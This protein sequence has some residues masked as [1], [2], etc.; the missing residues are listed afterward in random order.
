MTGLNT[1]NKD[2]SLARATKTLML[3][4]PF[5]GLLLLSLIKLWTKKINTAAVGVKG[6]NYNLFINDESLILFIF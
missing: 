5:Y 2:E 4:E 1:Y 6:M 3:K